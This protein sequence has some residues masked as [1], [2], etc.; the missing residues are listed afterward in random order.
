M[1]LLEFYFLKTA[2]KLFLSPTNYNKYI[3]SGGGGMY[4]MDPLKSKPTG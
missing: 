2:L 3:T 4:G 1:L